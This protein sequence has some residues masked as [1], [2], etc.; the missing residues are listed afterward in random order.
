MEETLFLTTRG[1]QEQEPLPLDKTR[2]DAVVDYLE[3][4]DT[5]P[6][7]EL[8]YLTL[9]GR[10]QRIYQLGKLSETEATDIWGTYGY[11]LSWRH[12]RHD[13]PHPPGALAFGITK[14]VGSLTE[15]VC[16]VQR[17]W[18]SRSPL[19]GLKALGTGVL[20]YQ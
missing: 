13:D 6:H 16:Q 14:A 5:S 17:S 19:K 11:Y 18:A 7:R 15:R 2:L 3:F 4:Q 9:A 10:Y 12:N 20:L 1:W 8:I